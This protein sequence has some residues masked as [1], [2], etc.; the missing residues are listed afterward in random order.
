MPLLPPSGR[1]LEKISLILL[2]MPNLPP[3]FKR[4]EWEI[5][6][7]RD[8][9]S[10]DKQLLW[11]VHI[12]TKTRSGTITIDE[13]VMQTSAGRAL[14]EVQVNRLVSDTYM[15]IKATE[16]EYERGAAE[17]YKQEFE[18]PKRDPVTGKFIGKTAAE[19]KAIQQSRAPIQVADQAEVERRLAALFKYDP[20]QDDLPEREIKRPLM[21]MPPPQKFVMKQNSNVSPGT[22]YTDPDTG[23]QSVWDGAMWCPIVKP[24]NGN[25]KPEPAPPTN[26]T[27]ATHKNRKFNLD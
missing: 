14:M 21:V 7:E 15:R 27:A 6:V 2:A 10:V 19:V 8:A 17:L 25:V 3:D 12:P 26:D 23:K 11:I 24:A 18:S 16:G 9:T 5:R 4:D 22:F 13:K 1:I 20:T